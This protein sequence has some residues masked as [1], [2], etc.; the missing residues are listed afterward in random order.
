MDHIQE[1]QLI[2]GVYTANLKAFADSRGS[3]AETFRKSWFPQRSWDV[4][5]TNRS[6]SQKGVLR[7]LHYHTQQV[8]YWY[9][10]R[11]R[12]RVGLADLRPDS[13]TYLATQ[14]IELGEE[15]NIGLFIPCEVA[16]G[17]VALTDATLTYIIDNYYNPD[18]ELGVYWNDPDLKMDWGISDPIISERDTQNPYLKDIVATTR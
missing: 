8:D 1:S 12:I 17:F 13:P 3:F 6:D 10:P 15:N 9:V 18:D 5:Q 7:G 4:F 11:G 2:T 14:M 16:H